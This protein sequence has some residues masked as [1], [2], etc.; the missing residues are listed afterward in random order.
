MV[1]VLVLPGSV[2]RMTACVWKVLVP[3]WYMISPPNV[4]EWR[5]LLESDSKG[6]LRPKRS[7]ECNMS[8]A[9]SEEDTSFARVWYDVLEVSVLLC[10]W[11]QTGV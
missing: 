7:I 11:G 9:G 8:P 10:L 2:L 6:V 4:P 5:H 3:V 1:Q